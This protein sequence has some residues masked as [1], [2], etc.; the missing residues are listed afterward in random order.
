MLIASVYQ[1]L[2][3][4][5]I[6]SKREHMFPT[7]TAIPLGQATTMWTPCMGYHN[8]ERRWKMQLACLGTK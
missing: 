6:R 8:A 2:V 4:F 5:G 1:S 7:A 3:C